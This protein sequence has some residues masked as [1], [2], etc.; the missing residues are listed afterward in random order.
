MEDECLPCVGDPTGYF[1]DNAEDDE[2]TIRKTRRSQVFK[3]N[4]FYQDLSKQSELNEKKEEN[5]YTE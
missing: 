5:I 4:E 3:P 2:P 1:P